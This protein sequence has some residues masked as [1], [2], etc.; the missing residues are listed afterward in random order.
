MTQVKESI[1]VKREQA[2]EEAR[3]KQQRTEAR[4]KAT[5]S[6]FQQQADEAKQLFDVKMKETE[7]KRMEFEKRREEEVASRREKAER[8]VLELAEVQRVAAAGVRVQ[9]V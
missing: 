3:L 9:C 6:F 4:I 2:K 5:Q 7:K 1:E 8:K